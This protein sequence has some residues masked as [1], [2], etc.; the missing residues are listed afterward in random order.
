MERPRRRLLRLVMILVLGGIGIGACLAALVPGV[1][2]VAGSSKYSGKVGPLLKKLDQPTTVYD[3]NG[4][5]LDTLGSHDRRPVPLSDVPKPLIN[6]IIATE[7]RTFYDNVGVDFQSMV[8]AFVTNI[9]SGDLEQGGSTITQ[10]LIKNRF[11]TKPKRDLDRKIK[12]A[13][14]AVRLNEEWSKNHILEEY[15]NTVYFGQGSYGVKAAAERFFNTPLDKI[16][17]AETALLAGLIKN[18]EGDNPFEHSQEATARRAEVLSRMLKQHYITKKE[19]FFAAASPL[20]LGPL[21]PSDFRPDNYYVAEAQRQLLNDKR[22]GETYDERKNSVNKGGLRVYTA[23]DPKLEALAQVAVSST[24]PDTRFTAALASVDPTNGD[25]K[26]IVAG[27]GFER[28]QVN[29]ATMPPAKPGEAS[30]RQPGSTFK[31]IVLATALE[32]GFSVKDS[33]DGTSPCTLHFK[34]KPE[35]A[36]PIKTQNAEGGGGVMS[37]RS[38]TVNSVNCAYFRLG[39]AVGLTKIVEMAKRLGVTHP[40]SDQ[41]YSLSIGSSDGVSP[42]DMA[43]VFATF[44][45]GGIKHDPVFIKK[46]EDVSGHVIF[47]NK[48]EGERVLDPQIALTVTDVLRGVITSGTGTRAKLVDR[49]AAGKTGTTD[50][51]SNAWFVGYTPQLVSA[52]WMGDPTAYTPMKNVG[53]FGE[54]FGGTYPALIWQ[55]FMTLALAGQPSQVFFPPD[56]RLWPRG[57]YVSENGRGKPSSGSGFNRTTTTTKP[58]PF[59]G[60]PP[61]ASTAPP[62]ASTVPPATTPTSAPHPPG[63]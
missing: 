19:A 39:A 24:L 46:V 21:P 4:D 37:L 7:D 28:S 34:G 26:A 8:R 27:P 43:T 2:K 31:A 5:Y 10:Q 25:V 3:V 63:P 41:N 47:E 15:L 62:P 18:P 55:K 45:S 57:V 23:Y 42:L 36:V 61:P 49:V 17:L 20:G 12:E 22:L 11:F 13:A 56:Q 50:D 14:L 6:A 29:L 44:A 35:P 52:V 1:E 33:V 38:A 58:A 53:R 59:R 51:E 48:G 9:D 54:V 16:T 60:F 32:N 40:I 30:G